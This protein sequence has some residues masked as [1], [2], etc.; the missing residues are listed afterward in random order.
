M[1]GGLND[2]PRRPTRRTRLRPDLAGPLDDVLVGA[3]LAQTDGAAGVQLLR[4]V[5]DLRAH[6]ELAAVGEPGRCVDVDARGVDA[7]LEG[8]GVAERAGH[9]GLRVAA[10]VAGDVLDR[11]PPGGGYPH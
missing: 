10:A 8:L 5:A 11:G 2:P 1:G 6:P 9:D 7:A 4:R 3:Q